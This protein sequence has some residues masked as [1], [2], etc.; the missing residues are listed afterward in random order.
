MSRRFGMFVIRT[1]KS[2][3]CCYFEEF[4]EAKMHKEHTYA[5]FN[6]VVRIIA[7]KLLHRTRVNVHMKLSKRTGVDLA[8]HSEFVHLKSSFKS[9]EKKIYFF[10]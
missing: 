3:Q 4:V 10:L 6:V 9:R 1:L 5:F 8:V 2:K 7:A